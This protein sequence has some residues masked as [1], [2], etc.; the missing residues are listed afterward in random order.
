MGSDASSQILPP[1]CV[2]KWELM[3]KYICIH[4]HFY[5]PPRENPWTGEVD[6]EESAKPYHDWNERIA[7]ECYEPNTKASILDASGQVTESVNNFSKISFDIGPTLLSWL[8]R[9]DPKTYQAILAADRESALKHNGHGNAMAQIYNHVIMPLC[10]RRDKITQV[11]WGI[12]DFEFHYKRKPE[13]M[14]LSEAAVD[15]ETLSILAENGILFTVLAP[16]QA[17][18]VRRV[19]FNQRWHPVR[20]ENVDSRHPYRILLRHGKQFHIFFYDAPI[21]RAIAFQ[22]LLN[23]G[24]QLTQKLLNAFGR[25]ESSQLVSTATDGESFGHHHRFGEMAI[26]Y[27]VKKIEKENLAVITNYADFLENSVSRWEVALHENSSWSCSHGVE[28]WRADCGCRINHAPGWN[29]KWRATLRLAFD[30]VKKTADHVFETQ[31]ESFLKDPWQARNDYIEVI[32]DPSE[33]VRKNFLSRQCKKT[34]NTEDQNKLWRLLEAQ[35]FTLFM[36]TSC[37][38]FFDD[39]AG[40]EPVQ[41]MKYALRA[42]ELLQPY[43]PPGMEAAFLKVL[44]HAKSN[45]PEEGSGAD[46]FERHVRTARPVSLK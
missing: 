25:N 13:G 18:S 6:V 11:V 15:R 23:N 46:V 5:Q 40:V 31:T 3:K 1:L 26:A 44:S 28:R 29:Q 38:W 34:I 39:I 41:M 16:H 37:A 33:A 2:V 12:K 36:Y 9:K 4:G 24:D 35:R 45:A 10:D 27:G 21:S 20:N 8:R 22:G 32:L 17:L 30:T 19:G 42:M 43:S 7:K 14:W